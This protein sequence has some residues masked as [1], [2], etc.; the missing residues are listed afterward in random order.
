MISL[1]EISSEMTSIGFGGSFITAVHYKT[2]NSTSRHGSTCSATIMDIG[3]DWSREALPTPSGNAKT[4]PGW[5]T[6][7]DGSFTFLDSMAPWYQGITNG[8]WSA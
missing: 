4:P 3:R 7:I 8:T 1:G 5:R 6:P 2:L